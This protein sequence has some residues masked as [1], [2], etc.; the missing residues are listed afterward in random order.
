[1][2]NEKMDEVEGLTL[3]SYIKT[4]KYRYK[5]MR[6]LK[7]YSLQ[8][9]TE[10]SKDTGILV[11][12]MSNVLRQLKEKNL[13]ECVNENSHKGRIYRLTSIGYVVANDYLPKLWE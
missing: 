3:A 9:P 8:T 12:H 10:I 6:S 11:S 13:I 5:V 2:E 4:S 7:K 1:M